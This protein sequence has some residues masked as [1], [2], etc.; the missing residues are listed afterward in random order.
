MSRD[1]KGS[2]SRDNYTSDEQAPSQPDWFK[3]YSAN[4]EKLSVQ[5][6]RK[7]RDMFNQISDILGTKSRYSSVEEAVTDMHSRTGLATYLQMCEADKAAVMSNEKL[8]SDETTEVTETTDVLP[9]QH[10]SEIEKAIDPNSDESHFPQLLKDHPEIGEFIKSF[11]GPKGRS[12]YIHVPAVVEAIR[13]MFRNKDF[14]SDELEDK[15]LR[16]F[17]NEE[18][19]KEKAKHKTDTAKDNKHLGELD[20]PGDSSSSNYENNDAFSILMPAKL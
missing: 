6:A 19:I 7:D 3:E 20:A 16:K 15:H 1:R 8:A 9:E 11:V 13:I 10:D 18:I 5:P 17:I 14:S 12:G 4:L 2:F